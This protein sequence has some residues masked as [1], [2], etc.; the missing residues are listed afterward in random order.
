MNQDD[1]LRLTFSTFYGATTY[2]DATGKDHSD[3]DGFSANDIDLIKRSANDYSYTQEAC[4]ILLDVCDYFAATPKEDLDIQYLHS[5]PQRS[6]DVE[7]AARRQF[8]YDLYSQLSARAK[9][10][11]D[12]KMERIHETA[13]TGHGSSIREDVDYNDPYMRDAIIANTERAC[14]RIRA[15]YERMESKNW[16]QAPSSEAIQFKPI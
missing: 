13:S 12:A 5:E 10:I 11:F 1:R 6:H 3:L 2:V 15:H 4:K 9:D 7:E 8:M 16:I 14:A